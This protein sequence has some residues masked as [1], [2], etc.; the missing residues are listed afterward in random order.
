MDA[1][2]EV[3]DAVGT[4]KEVILGAVVILGDLTDN[5]T[6]TCE[7][8]SAATEEQTASVQEVNALTDTNRNVAS[9]LADRV[10]RFKTV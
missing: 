5:L 9:E 4:S 8:I 7:Q 1:V 2:V 3:N 10:S 6:A